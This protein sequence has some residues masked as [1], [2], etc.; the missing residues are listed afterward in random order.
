MPCWIIFI[1]LLHS[2]LS[3]KRTT[4]YFFPPLFELCTGIFVGVIAHYNYHYSPHREFSLCSLTSHNLSI[5]TFFVSQ[6]IIHGLLPFMIYH[7]QHS[8][9][10]HFL[11][12][13]LFLYTLHHY[14]YTKTFII[15]TCCLF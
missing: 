8:T 9:Y 10:T 7:Q 2:P 5:L 3:E 6:C 4:S 14:A 11:Q 1:L 12:P 15:P 13:L